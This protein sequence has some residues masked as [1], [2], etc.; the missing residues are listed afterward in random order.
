MGSVEY[1]EMQVM[2]KC[3]NLPLQCFGMTFVNDNNSRRMILTT[4]FFVISQ[5]NILPQKRLEDIL[6]MKIE[7]G[8]VEVDMIM[9]AMNEHIE[10][11]KT[12]KLSYLQDNEEPQ[13][14]YNMK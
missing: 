5:L 11:L 6:K 4:M 9:E 10:H 2:K 3:N 7:L 13:I 1:V 12:Y 8:V 14:S